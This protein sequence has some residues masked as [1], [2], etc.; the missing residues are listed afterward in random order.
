MT[1]KIHQRLA[2]AAQN[3][4]ADPN[5]LKTHVIPGVPVEILP[6]F[7]S[8]QRADL[9][10]LGARNKGALGRKVLG[11]TTEKALRSLP[12]PVLVVPPTAASAME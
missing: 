11:A 10:A 12:I 4:G 9:L 3:W 1:A 8:S 6:R 7:I 2:E 5:R